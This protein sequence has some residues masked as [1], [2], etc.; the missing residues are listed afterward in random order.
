MKNS[1]KITSSS[2]VCPVIEVEDGEIAFELNDDLM[3]RL[4]LKTGD[5]IVFKNMLKD[6]YSMVIMRKDD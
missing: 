1:N 6:R 3:D 2:W 5:T 4:N